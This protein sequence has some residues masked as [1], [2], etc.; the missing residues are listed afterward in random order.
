[1]TAPKDPTRTASPYKADPEGCIH[2][3]ARQLISTHLLTLGRST[4]VLGNGDAR[5]PVLRPGAMDAARLP[6]RMGQQLRWPD[7]RATPLE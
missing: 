1:M 7:G 4:T 6:S 5:P 2:P 3:E